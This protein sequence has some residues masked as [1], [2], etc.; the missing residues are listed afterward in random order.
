MIA[1]II[2]LLY[3]RIFLADSWAEVWRQRS[4][5]YTGLSAT[6]LILIALVVVNRALGGY[7][8]GFTVISPWRYAQNQFGA[9]AHYLRLAFWPDTLCLD[10]GW[11]ASSV[12]KSWILA[13]TMIVSPLLPATVWTLER[14]PT[15]GFLGAWFFLTLAPSS[16]VVPI[17]D[18]V[19]ERRMYL[20]LAAVVTLAV[21]AVW[22]GLSVLSRH[23]RWTLVAQRSACFG[24]TI[25]IAGALA[26]RTA[27][28][29]QEYHN[30]IVIWI[31]TIHQRPQNPRAWNNL[32]YS[33]YKA[34][35]FDLAI[36]S[37]QRAIELLP[38]YSVTHLN[39]GEV[40]IAQGRYQEAITHLSEA[41]RLNAD[42]ADAHNDLGYALQ[43]LGD[44]EKAMEHFRAA[45]RLR[46]DHPRAHYNLSVVLTN[47]GEFD[48]ALGELQ[49]VRRLLPDQ[50]EIPY[51]LGVLLNSHGRY[52]EACANFAEAVRL[53]PEYSEAYNEL[54]F[55]Y[56]NLQRYNEA[57]ASFGEA[58][59]IKADYGMA[60]YNLGI[61]YLDMRDK[62]RAM[63]QYRI[64]Q[65][66]D[67]D[68]AAKLYAQISK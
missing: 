33:Y 26:W 28:R 55:A 65:R 1:P 56:L 64:L 53:K 21:I 50:P 4:G 9:I 62:N 29:N 46:P 38:T 17:Q 61:T 18:M 67:K 54:G 27:K 63:E 30:A 52:T 22:N 15:L 68:R 8:P 45:I 31:N 24:L 36:T 19:A 59:R 3:D 32:G 7:L 66:I 13:G 47:L 34:G 11:Q 12:P 44:R 5:L 37:Y 25:L 39:L 35:Q 40:R 6:W 41:L 14:A 51:K 20:P 48:D 2:V 57:L 60:H 58:V 49:T 10:Y 16:S 43:K 42:N 23:F